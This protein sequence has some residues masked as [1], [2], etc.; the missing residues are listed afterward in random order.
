VLHQCLKLQQEHEVRIKDVNR[1][2]TSHAR[3]MSRQ[4][5]Q[6]SMIPVG[7]VVSLHGLTARKDLNGVEAVVREYLQVKGRYQV[8]LW[9]R[10]GDGDSA[11]A[12]ANDV[13]Q[14]PVLAKDDPTVIQLKGGQQFAIRPKNLTVLRLPSAST[15]AAMA[16]NDDDDSAVGSSMPVGP[17]ITERQLTA[18]QEAVLDE[19]VHTLEVKHAFEKPVALAEIQA[20]KQVCSTNGLL[21]TC[22]SLTLLLHAC[23]H[24]RCNTSID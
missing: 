12:V 4:A 9:T 14:S 16:D 17:V 7:T 6:S 1:R 5:S 3:G 19:W 11:G 13:P 2:S 23:R 20:L 22:L 8:T 21:N 10:D 18:Q 24:P 15:A